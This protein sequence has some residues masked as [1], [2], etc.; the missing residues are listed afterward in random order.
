MVIGAATMGRKMGKKVSPKILSLSEAI[1]NWGTIE[2]MVN[3]SLLGKGDSSGSCALEVDMSGCLSA[4]RSD[5]RER[6]CLSA[7]EGFLLACLLS[8]LFDPALL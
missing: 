8:K 7:F 6:P 5:M 4:H 1:V 3:T 2:L